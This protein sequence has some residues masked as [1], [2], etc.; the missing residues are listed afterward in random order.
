MIVAIHQPCF[1]PWLGYLQRMAHADIFVLLDHV[2]FERAN[3]QNRTRVRMRAGAPGASDEA[4][5]ITVPV[6]QRSRSERILEKEI[7]N[8]PAG[9]RWNEAA[10]ATLRHAYREA[11]Y[12]NLYFPALKDLLD[13]P[14]T[15]LVDLNEA[16]LE[17]LRN[18][19]GIRTPIVKS[20]E[21]GVSGA[22]SALILEICLAL[23]ADA[24]LGGLG[25]SRGYIDEAAFAR[26][27][28]RV[29][30]QDFLHP[31]YRQCGMGPFIPGLSGLDLL[32]NAG[33]QARHLFLHQRRAEAAAG[34]AELRQAA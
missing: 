2:Q 15:R 32:L 9:R 25:G 24:F 4:R 27:G 17:L 6:I 33:P 28:V 26:A 11:P 3:Y 22:K 29:L 5:W 7:D 19:F 20:S 16:G 8:R 14:W 18:A 21:L 12:A 23:G 31:E 1:L 13:A 10:L 30:W 34:A